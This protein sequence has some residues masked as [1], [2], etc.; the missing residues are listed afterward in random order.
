M[1]ALVVTDSI[2]EKHL[3]REHCLRDVGAARQLRDAA[4]RAQTARSRAEK[5]LAHLL[6]SDKR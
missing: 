3:S 1:T 4:P 5:K 2:S 6:R